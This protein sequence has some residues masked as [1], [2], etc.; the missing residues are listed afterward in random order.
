[1]SACAVVIPAFNEEG[2]IGRVVHDLS[3][4]A[5]VIVVDDASWDGTAGEAA[6][7]GATVVQL[8]RTGG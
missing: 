8:E 5:S 4:I 6:E 1:M 3:S 2:T 7:A